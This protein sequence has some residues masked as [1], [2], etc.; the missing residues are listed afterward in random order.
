MIKKWL[1]MTAAAVLFL[2]LNACH[3]DTEPSSSDAS[4]GG[5]T[6]AVGTT[7]PQPAEGRI[8]N[9]VYT[10]PDGRFSLG[11]PDSW[12]VTDGD[13]PYIFQASNKD[14]LV[15]V[16]DPAD[17]IGNYT[18]DGIA[19]SLAADYMQFQRLD[20][21]ELTIGNRR[22]LFCQYQYVSDGVTLVNSL[23]LIDG[24]ASL[25]SLTYTVHDR[26]MDAAVRDSALSFALKS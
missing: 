14:G 4:K 7:A 9:G 11:V 16:E 8:V 13:G 3:F 2:S 10:A 1:G 17:A 24:G 12:S 26:S 6:G 18:P 15:L 21:G 23:Y 22:A 25:F 20:G 5:P 19:D